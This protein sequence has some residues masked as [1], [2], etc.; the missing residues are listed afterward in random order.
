MGMGSGKTFL[1]LLGVARRRSA[2]DS[3]L[4]LLTFF[5]GSSW[6]SKGLL[7]SS[8]EGTLTFWRNKANSF[9]ACCTFTAVIKL[10]MQLSKR[11]LV[12][13]YNCGDLSV[14]LQTNVLAN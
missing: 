1:R 13:T 14:T 6:V 7:V 9:Q 4:L 11:S 10:P 3:F 12:F 8:V 5:L 2:L